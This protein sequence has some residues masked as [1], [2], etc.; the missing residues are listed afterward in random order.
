MEAFNIGGKAKHAE[1]EGSV[2][3]DTESSENEIKQ[4]IVSA[5]QK[6]IGMVRSFHDESQSPTK[7]GQMADSL[8]KFNKTYGAKTHRPI[9]KE[10]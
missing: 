8:K 10:E 3:H 1:A 7:P 4:N 9:F 6:K 5:L 2:R